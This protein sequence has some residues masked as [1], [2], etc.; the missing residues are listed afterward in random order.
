M[1]DKEIYKARAEGLNR[2]AELRSNYKSGL[3]LEL[4]DLAHTIAKEN[5]RDHEKHRELKIW[6]KV[7][8]RKALNK[9]FIK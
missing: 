1:T 2:I 8:F 3:F 6:E 9:L 4:L 5:S 7:K